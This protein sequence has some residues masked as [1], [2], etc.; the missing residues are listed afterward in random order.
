MTRPKGFPYRLGFACINSIL[1]E[2]KPPIFCSRT[3]RESTIKLK[4]KEYLMSLGKENLAGLEKL[5][6][7]NEENNIKFMRMSSNMFPFASHNEYGYSLEYCADELLR[8]G[9]LAR[10][11]GHRLTTH[12]SQMNNLGSP[13]RKVVEDTARDLTYHCEMLD[14]MGCDD[15]SVMIIHLGGIYQDK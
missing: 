15:S 8:I 5:I 7:W 11:L 12:P 14:R 10:T 1:R 9:T 2:Q 13:T 6:L 3:C 4:G